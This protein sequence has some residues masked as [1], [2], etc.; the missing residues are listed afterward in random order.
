MGESTRDAKQAKPYGLPND[1]T[2]ESLAREAKELLNDARVKL[3]DAGWCARENCRGPCSRRVITTYDFI[4]KV[5]SMSESTREIAGQ[6]KPMS[7]TD[8]LL[9]HLAQECCEVAIRCTKA[10]HFGLDEV[11]PEQGMTNAERIAEELCDLYAMVEELQTAGLLPVFSER[12]KQARI[13]AKQRKAQNF[14]NYSREL[15]RLQ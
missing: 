8:Y 13:G 3:G 9:S 4:A 1:A 12:D 7:Y 6:D 2:S 11:Q 15:G 10:Q 5:K 14:R